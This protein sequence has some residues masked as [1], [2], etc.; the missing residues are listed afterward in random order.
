MK[1]FHPFYLIGSIGIIVV[2][3][4]HI[5]LALGLSVSS[6]HTLFFVLYPVFIAFLIIGLAF[7]LKNQK[8]I[9]KTI[10]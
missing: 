8:Q 6:V 9:N 4:L 5:F 3:L 1:K 10:E 2:S 7:T